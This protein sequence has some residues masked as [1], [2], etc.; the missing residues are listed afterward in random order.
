MTILNDNELLDRWV[1]QRDAEA[2][3]DLAKLNITSENLLVVRVL[4]PTNEPIDDV[5]LKQTPHRNKVAPYVTGGSY[6]S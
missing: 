5:I 6:N 3:K 2:F 1:S 4:N